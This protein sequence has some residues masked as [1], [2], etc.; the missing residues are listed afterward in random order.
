MTA[1]TGIIGIKRNILGIRK[2]DDDKIFEYRS[3][4]TPSDIRH[5]K[6][7]LKDLRIIVES[8]EKPDQKYHRAY[9]D[10]EF[11]E[12]GAEV[13][14]ISEADIII[15]IKEVNIDKIFPG[16][17]Y[18]FFSHTYKAQLYNM[19]MLRKLRNLGCSLLDYELVVEDVSDEVYR[20]DQ[21]KREIYFGH[22][23]GFA[24][25]VDT[26]HGLG[27][28]FS[29]KGFQTP[30]D[31]V[32][33]SVNYTS[34]YGDFG[35][36]SKALKS[37]HEVGREISQFGL[38]SEICPIV[39][40][41]TGSG[42]VTKS[43]RKILSN[44]PCKEITLAQLS[45]RNFI[46][47][48]EHKH[49]IYIVQFSR[50]KRTEEIFSQYLPLL[51]VL[52][53]G[54]KWLSSQERI[55]TRKTLANLSSSK[56]EII[57]DITCDPNGAIEIS[58][59]TYAD[60]PFFTYFAE[61]D[62]ENLDW[63]DVQFSSSCVPGVAARGITVMAV[64]NLPTEFAREASESFSEML[65]RFVDKLICVD[66]PDNFDELNIERQLKRS[67]ILYK[68]ELT[69]DF[70]H[71]SAHVHPR[72]AIIG[73]GRMSTVVIDYLV[74]KTDFELIL[75]DAD[76]NQAQS[77]ADKY[78]SDRFFGVHGIKV[79]QHTSD[80]ILLLRLL[81]E[82]DVVISLLPS[83]LHTVIARMA[84]LS[85]THL[86]TASYV[87]DEMLELNEMARSSGVVLLNEVGVDPGLDHMSIMASIDDLASR[88]KH[89]ISL[90][91]YCGGIPYKLHKPNP[92]N[93]KASWSPDGILNA[94]NRPARFL[95]DG[96]VVELTPSQVFSN[97]ELISI[98]ANDS[99]TL[100]AYPNGDSIQYTKIYGLDQADTLIRGTLRHIGWCEVFSN[101]HQ[102]G[103]F[104]E[105][106]ASAVA[107]RQQ[108]DF[109]D[110]L[111]LHEKSTD[112]ENISAFEYIKQ[113]FISK[114][115]LQYEYGEQDQLIMHHQITAI[116]DKGEC[117]VL[118][119]QLHVTGDVDGHSAMAKTVGLPCAIA[120]RLIIEKRLTEVG[121]Q[122]PIT[123]EIYD[124]ILS[125]LRQYGIGFSETI[126]RK[127]T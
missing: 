30:F 91:S 61:L 10:N 48:D 5:L 80:N 47:E 60:E 14:D 71:L 103:W 32:K 66:F 127:T 19:P 46:K 39:I 107:M 113:R 16:K 13:G 15:G 6:D 106:S 21:F 36:L 121:V 62:D 122:L 90:V 53:H 82:S 38:P 112:A 86:V 100:E 111:D 28:R 17:T 55:V 93:Y 85:K 105:V 3:P 101:L 9:A 114:S 24:G 29:A 45:D 126:T 72:V 54:A 59:P 27:K 50:E 65:S 26:L 23:A 22:M 41:L 116:D 123:K 118:V 33:K 70:K 64:T 1:K 76:P 8:G 92:L 83:H 81:Q 84:I 109:G 7:Q 102:A 12:A 2:E 77:V 87:S 119:S 75:V 74:S 52:I 98:E 108:S 95:R 89:V 79:N 117:E 63:N 104:S 20:L 99:I 94:V 57:G 78:P 125:E 110:W 4:L 120:A 73:A 25:T 115:D 42:N 88:G 58:R 56:L 96:K 37:L 40:G 18:L 35:D 11:L 44:L 69:P 68:G 97:S 51:T 34:T 67:F 43:V 49:T 124:P 31:Q